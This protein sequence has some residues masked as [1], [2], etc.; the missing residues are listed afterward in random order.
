MV[1]CVFQS[2]LEVIG[3]AS[4]GFVRKAFVEG[5]AVAA[6]YMSRT[7]GITENSIHNEIL[8]YC[9]IANK[10]RMLWSPEVPQ[11]IAVGVH[12]WAGPVIVT[13]MVGECSAMGCASYAP[14]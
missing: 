9:Y 8:V 5:V 12:S 7:N 10:F 4:Y 3:E 11:L 6:K 14:F 1:K 13:E 2:H